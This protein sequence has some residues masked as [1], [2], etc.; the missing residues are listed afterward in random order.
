[1]NSE[2]RDNSTV[3]AAL[4]QSPPPA[5]SVSQPPGLTEADASIQSRVNQIGTDEE[6]APDILAPVSSKGE[7]VEESELPYDNL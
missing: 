2:A 6:T 4:I 1:M 3:A 7:R 5:L